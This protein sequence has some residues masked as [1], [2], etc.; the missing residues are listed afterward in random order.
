MEKVC[1][2][3]LAD[4]WHALSKRLPIPALEKRGKLVERFRRGKLDV[5]GIQETHTQEWGVME[6]TTRS[7]SKDGRE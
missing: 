7:E 4:F 3:D 2:R 5:I 1:V 6:C